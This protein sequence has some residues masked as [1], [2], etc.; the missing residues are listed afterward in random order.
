MALSPFRRRG[1]VVLSLAVTLPAL[2]LAAIAVGLTLRISRAV[3]DESVRFNTYLAQLVAEAFE[4]ELMDHLRHGVVAAENVARSDGTVPQIL[5]ALASESSEFRGPHFVGLDELNGYSLLII[6][7]QPLIYSVGDGAHAGEQFSGVLMRDAEGQ[8]LGAGG[9]WMSSREF[10]TGHLERVVQDRLPSNPRMYG[11]FEST[12]RLSVQLFDPGGLEI[13]RVRT[14]EYG[15]TARIEALQG[16]FDG[17][18]VR[19]AATATST[20]VWAGR[21]VTLQIA[22]IVLMALAVV[23]ASV[24]S[25]RYTVRQLELAQMKAG[26]VSN[27]THELKTPIALIRLAVE[28]LE[29]KRVRSPEEA[30]KFL[31]MIGRETIRLSHLVDNILDFAR[32]EAGQRVFRMEPVP[33]AQ[34]VEE[35]LETFRPRLE[36]L[37]FTLEEQIPEG[38]PRVNVDGT[39]ITHCVLNLLDNAVKYS[40]ERKLIRVA[41]G[42]NGDDVW[43]S[44]T[45]QGIGIAP[46]DRERVFE[47]FVRLETG[48]IH[49]VKGS[50]LGLSLVAQILAAH[51]GR[52]EVESEPG[53]GSTFTLHLPAAGGMVSE[54]EEPG[55]RTAS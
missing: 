37:G 23:V 32:L 5:S 45:D 8:V 24:F 43:I 36:H 54:P 16:P 20:V 51:G 3:E 41:A 27:V 29:L 48:L 6:E 47:K 50:G 49:D 42:A 13:G 28:T 52:V 35:A 55:R 34:I 17:Y 33:V 2:V 46:A 11:G 22:F 21:F 15:R 31:H 7:S 39:A 10:L 9:W 14:P 30:E 25:L 18:S 19:V 4:Q 1:L 12:R 44:V 26:F 38:L 53:R 40:K